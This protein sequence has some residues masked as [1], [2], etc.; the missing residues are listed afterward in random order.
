MNQALSM[1][2]QNNLTNSNPS[3]VQSNVAVNAPHQQS[4]S[5]APSS[6][7]LSASTYTTIN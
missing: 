5:V 4:T 1:N 2:E 7:L 3:N 6:A